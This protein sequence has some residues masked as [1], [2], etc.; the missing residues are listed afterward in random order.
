[1]PCS[2]WFTQKDDETGVKEYSYELDPPGRYLLWRVH[3]TNP[4]GQSSVEHAS[5]VYVEL[6][7]LCAVQCTERRN[8]V[9]NFKSLLARDC[10]GHV[11]AG[12]YFDLA[13]NKDKVTIFCKDDE[14]GKLK[15]KVNFDVFLEKELPSGTYITQKCVLNAFFV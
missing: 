7:F 8:L 13:L 2:G 11:L 4:R 1:V 12:L 9:Y 3:E 10:K 5:L 15:M 14:G 6:P